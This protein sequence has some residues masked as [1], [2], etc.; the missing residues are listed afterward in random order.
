MTN[1]EL[2]AL[3]RVRAMAATGQAREVRTRARLSLADVA[4]VLGVGVSTVARW[5]TG[6]RAPQA[7]V[8]LRYAKLLDDLVLEGAA[9]RSKL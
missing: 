1:N 5:E 9:T 4:G 7:K 6:Q 2:R 8:A 3:A